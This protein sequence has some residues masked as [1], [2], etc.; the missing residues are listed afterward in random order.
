MSKTTSDTHQKGSISVSKLTNGLTVATDTMRDVDSIV[1]C[2]AVKAGSCNEQLENNGISHFLEHMA[3]KGTTT[4][5]AKDIAESV[6][7]KGGMM[8]AFTSKEITLYYI[9]LLKTD[10]K[11]AVEI[12]GDIMQNSTF[13]ETEMERERGVILQELASTLDTPDDVVFDHFFEKAY[14]DTPL[15]MTIL[16]SA[17]NIKKL[18]KKHFTD[19][20]S[21]HYHPDNMV[22]SVC[23]NIKHE[24]FVKLAEDSFGEMKKKES[25]LAKRSQA[26]LSV[27]TGGEVINHKADL[28]QMQ[29]L[30]GF[31]SYPYMNRKKTY[32]MQIVNGIL[33]GGSSSRMFQE[34][35]EVR[36]LA[37]SISTFSSSQHD[38]G[39]FC[40]YADSSVDKLESLIEGVTSVLRASVASIGDKEVEKILNQY[41]ASILMSRESTNSRSTKLATDL[42]IH[43]K[44][45]YPEEIMSQIENFSSKEAS[46]LLAEVIS[47]TDT[48]TLALY[49]NFAEY[50]NGK[51][52]SKI[53]RFDPKTL[54]KA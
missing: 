20:V 1:V 35:R 8:N 36:G 41:R 27:Y 44:Y 52:L 54:L 9:K 50:S 39:M 11:L 38:N 22:L 30:L 32:Q 37:Y 5:T 46:A 26:G 53:E 49:G 33:G 17:S 10:V 3:F 2:V 16:G 23:G 18:N 40:V 34:I 45:I 31:K 24:E 15:A 19:Y 25:S 12:L 29:F 21:T 6:E 28:E 4:R 51:N 47:Q 42:L 48:P 14:K 7:S 43:E 13:D